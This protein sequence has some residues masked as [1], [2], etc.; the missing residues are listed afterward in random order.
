MYR[1]GRHRRESSLPQMGGDTA[2]MTPPQPEARHD[3]NSWSRPS[4]PSTITACYSVKTA[5]FG[6]TSWLYSGVGI[7]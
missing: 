2:P 6:S 7:Q 5:I 1:L 4:K 3:S